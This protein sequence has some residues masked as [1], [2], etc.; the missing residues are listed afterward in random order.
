M[1]DDDKVKEQSIISKSK[2]LFLKDDLVNLDDKTRVYNL[3]DEFAKTRKNKDYVFYAWAGGFILGVVI[4]ALIITSYIRN[5]DRRITF[6]ISDF[7]DIKLNEIL[8]NVKKNENKMDTAQNQLSEVKIRLQKEIQKVRK[9]YSDKREEVYKKGYSARKTKELVKGITADENKAVA[10][11]NTKYKN[12]IF[13]KRSQ[14]NSIQG[15][16]DKYDSKLKETADKA[17]EMVN[18]FK[19][20]HKIKM[21]KQKQE[22]IMK[23]NPYFSSQSLLQVIHEKPAVDEHQSLRLKSFEPDIE[24]KQIFSKTDFN[25]LRKNISQQNMIIS[26]LRKIPYQN[27][28]APSLYRLEYVSK[29]IINDYEELWSRLAE[30]SLLLNNY[31]RAFSYLAQDQ[32][33]TGYIVDPSDKGNVLVFIRKI[34]DISSGTIGL[35]FRSDD[36][37]IGKVKLFKMAGEIK[38]EIVELEKDKE[39]QPFDKILIQLQKE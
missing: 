12:Q 10:Q 11:V 5:Q 13:E 31:N 20:L 1:G 3:N 25:I 26:R 23:Y 36:E 7:A 17:E 29:A 24:R 2:K 28:V 32:S 16:I 14:I 37:Y 22:L 34:H 30:K 6:Q 35:V 21:E 8:D 33:E 9:K 19:R 27:S 4:F 15:D 39:M 38:A 18:N